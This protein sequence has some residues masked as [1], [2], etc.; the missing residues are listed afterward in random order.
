MWNIFRKTKKQKCPDIR[1][2]I[3]DE[4]RF[5]L[6]INLIHDIHKALDRYN[7]QVN[8]YKGLFNVAKTYN[9]EPQG[10]SDTEPE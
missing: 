8:H 2:D 7:A 1:T 3:P 5:K 10:D 6:L 4:I 9:N